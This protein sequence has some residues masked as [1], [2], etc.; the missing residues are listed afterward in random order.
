M[1]RVRAILVMAGFLG[2]TLPLMPLQKVFTLTSAAAARRFPHLYH[3]VLAKLLGFNIAVAG[4][5]P[6]AGPVLLVAN[7]ASWIDIVALSSLAPL[8]FIAKRDVGSWPLFGQLAKLQRTVFIDRDRRQKTGEARTEISA[9]LSGGDILVLFPEGTSHD[10]INVLPFKSSL[11]GLAEGDAV[12]IVPVTIAYHRV[13]G[14]PMTRRQRPFYAFYGD[15]EM[16]P[17]LWE[18]IKAGPIDISITLHAPLTA[19]GRKALANQAETTIRQHLAQALHGRGQM[20]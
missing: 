14:L 16:R 13:R 9:R 6:K 19:T 2:L 20:R 5:V 1:S 18:A 12:A 15:M 3:Q 7:H 4:D 11:F 10:G 17:H 8:S